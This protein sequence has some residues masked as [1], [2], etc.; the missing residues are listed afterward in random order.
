MAKKAVPLENYPEIAARL[1]EARKRRKLTL[2]EVG[3][4]LGV[5]GNLVGDW[6]RGRLEPPAGAFLKLADLY[7]VTVSWLLGGETAAGQNATP[8][9]AEPPSTVA[10]GIQASAVIQEAEVLGQEL[11]AW[12]KR[13][14][15]RRPAQWPRLV[16]VVE[17]ARSTWEREA[18]S[19]ESPDDSATAGPAG[20][21][22]ARGDR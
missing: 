18:A 22:A 3:E 17:E 4:Y 16:A 9:D 7:N 19:R 11:A 13:Q 12:L 6:E 8:P 2:A 20:H 1:K 15:I 10:L 14:A 21:K 5:T